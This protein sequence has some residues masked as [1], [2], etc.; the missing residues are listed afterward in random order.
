MSDLKRQNSG[1]ENVAIILKDLFS[2]KKNSLYTFVILYKIT[3]FDVKSM[4]N[5]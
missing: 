4:I 5:L 1:K 2:N 3:R